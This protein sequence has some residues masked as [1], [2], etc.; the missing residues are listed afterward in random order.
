MTFPKISYIQH[1]SKY[2]VYQ[3]QFHDIYSGHGHVVLNPRGL[4]FPMCTLDSKDRARLQKGSTCSSISFDWCS[5]EWE[6][7]TRHLSAMQL[8]PFVVSRIFQHHSLH[9]YL[10]GGSFPKV[11][12]QVEALFLFD[13]LRTGF[14]DSLDKILKNVHRSSHYPI[15]IPCWIT[16]NS[17]PDS[18]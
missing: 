6:R 9:E 2:H 15:C 1:Q 16:W 4:G 3:A 5:N 11:Q 14:L 17:C 13:W 10:N 8:Q 18:S 12:E 7:I